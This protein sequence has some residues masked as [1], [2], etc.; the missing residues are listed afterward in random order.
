MPIDFLLRAQEVLLIDRSD[1]DR[2]VVAWVGPEI[3]GLL[4]QESA[5]VAELED[6]SGIV[7]VV[8]EPSRVGPPLLPEG[9]NFTA[10]A[11]STGSE[12]TNRYAMAVRFRFN[13]RY[14]STRYGSV[15]DGE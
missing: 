14:I 7:L 3:A 13:C 5:L 8:P 15:F 9:P 10:I 4:E 11:T 12:T 2:V 1:Q 6:R